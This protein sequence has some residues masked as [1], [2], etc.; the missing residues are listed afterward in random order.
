MLRGVSK[1]GDV[2]KLR[3]D[4][5]L[6]NV[7]EAEVVLNLTKNKLRKLIELSKCGDFTFITSKI[8]ND[9]FYLSRGYV[10][11]KITIGFLKGVDLR[12]F[13][14]DTN[15]LLKGADFQVWN[16]SWGGAIVASGPNMSVNSY[17]RVIKAD[18]A[19]ELGITVE[20]LIFSDLNMSVEYTLQGGDNR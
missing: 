4:Q 16:D 13:Q 10:P 19:F 15:A 20:V 14:R 7:K 6:S 8:R 18:H 1:M 17:N 5:I 12:K 11:S 2:N 3:A 9:D